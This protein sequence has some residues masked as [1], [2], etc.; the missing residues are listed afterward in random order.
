MI[1]TT[2]HNQTTISKK[3]SLNGVGLHTGKDVSITF[4]PS[5]S[6]TGYCFKRIDLDN[7]PIVEANINYV[8]NTERGT[9]L[10]KNNVIIQTCEHVLASLVGLEI[11]N[12]LIEL[13]ASEPPI[14]DGSSKYFIEALETAGI[15]ELKEKRKE[16]VVKNVI[17]YK[18]KESGS[19]ITVIP[20]D[21]YQVTTMVD[22]GTK[23]LGTQNASISS[24]SEFK[25]NISSCRTFSF[26]HEI[27][28]LLNKGLIKGGDLNN[29]IVYVDKP[30]SDSTMKKLK[31]AFNKDKIKIKSNGIL[32][33]LTL[34]YPNEAARHKL[35]DVIGDLAL[36]GTKIRGKVIANKPG[37]F[38]NTKF[39]KKMKDII[40]DSK[41]ND[42]PQVDFSSAPLLDTTKIM[43]IL[44]HRPPFLFI[45][46]IY[47]LT[48]DLV[49]G[50][51]NVTI[52][53][54]FFKGH[55]PDYPV[56]P[57]VIII[58]AMAQMGGILVMSKLD[59]PQNYLTFFAKIDKV[60]FRNKVLPGDT[61]IFKCS[62]LGPFRRGICH[63]QGLAYANDKLC[64]EA[65]LTAQITKVK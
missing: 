60:R 33:N 54:D 45:D 38:I 26:L 30:L 36:I 63:M 20:A 6:N 1:V 21:E 46:K 12:V 57:G 48:D 59:D 4:Q 64:A 50:V 31:K 47:E 7:Q 43:E 17:S 62:L 5:E 25:D 29:A 51:K 24:I 34:H 35:L 15:K 23:I 9:C 13:D 16:F 11:D 52:D 19:E 61:I 39:S 2:N 41:K 32:D 42:I 58:E 22:F 28:M 8:T 27:E 65:E 10:N 44:P 56:M 37:H 14:M 40:K 49:I 3:V 18:D 55:F 53:E